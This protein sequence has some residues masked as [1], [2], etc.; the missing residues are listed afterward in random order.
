MRLP[1]GVG[2]RVERAFFYY[3]LLCA[4]SY[5]VAKIVGVGVSPYTTLLSFAPVL[6]YELYLAYRYNAGDRSEE[7]I[8]LVEEDEGG[9]R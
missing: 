1:R 5:W 6:A 3:F 8:F 9:E 4:V 7:L 2:K